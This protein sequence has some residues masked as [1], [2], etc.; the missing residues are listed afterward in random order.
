VFCGPFSGFLALF[1]LDISSVPY[2]T[3]YDYELGM[4]QA[5]KDYPGMIFTCYFE[6]MKSVS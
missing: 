6:D 1:L 3:W 2:G 4:E 5:E